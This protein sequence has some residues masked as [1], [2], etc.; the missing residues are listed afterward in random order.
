MKYKVFVLDEDNPRITNVDKFLR[1]TNADEFPQFI[2]ALKGD[3]AGLEKMQI[4]KNK[5][6]LG[7]L[8]FEI[9]III[10]LLVMM[11]GHSTFLEL[12]FRGRFT[13]VAFGLFVLKMVTTYYTKKQWGII[14]ILGIVGIISYFTSGDEYVIRMIVLAFASRGI[15]WKR[16]WKL[17]FVGTLIGTIIIISFSCIGI[18]GD[19]KT[20]ADF[21]RGGIETRYTLG[22]NH[23]NNLHDILWYMLAILLLYTNNKWSW[24]HYFGA[25]LVNLGLFLLTVSRNGMLAVQIL[26]IG[27]LLFSCMPILTTKKTPYILGGISLC[28]FFWMTWLG[29]SYG[30]GRSKLVAF[31]NVYLNN[32]MEMV[33]EYAPVS[34]WQAF[35]VWRELEKVDN[36]F[37]S[38]F[39]HYGYI[40]GA[41][42]VLVVICL[43]YILYKKQDGVCLCVLVTTLFITFIEA[44]FVFNASLLCNLVVVVAMRCLQEE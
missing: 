1:R 18:A 21:G 9:G 19:T 4:I 17:I 38:L 40:V 31:L 39:F 10:E 36:G 29:G 16:T 2:N 44:T 7:N 41:L 37:A 13:H 43:I 20:V 33:W 23:A 14:G 26:L 22:F 24:K 5:E 34:S 35:P 30:I 32:R 15:D 28:V 6:K 3:M 12:P 42:Y 8:L 27:S 11:T 25:T